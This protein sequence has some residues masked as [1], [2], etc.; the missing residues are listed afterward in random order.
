MATII[1][2][3]GGAGGGLAF[4]VVGGTTQPSNPSENTVWV[5]TSTAI[6]NVY[7]QVYAPANPV[8]GDVWVNTWVALDGNGNPIVSDPLTMTVAESPF[9]RITASSGKQW[10]GM[11]W[12][13]YPTKVYKNG[14]WSPDV[15]IILNAGS[16]GTF[17]QPT[18]IF[19]TNMEITG[20]NA[21]KYFTFENGDLLYQYPSSSTTVPFRAYIETPIDVSPYNTMKVISYKAKGGS[22]WA[23]LN[24][25]VS[26]GNSSYAES[27]A[28]EKMTGGTSASPTE[29][30]L[31]ISSASGQMYFGI[32]VYY[33]NNKPGA[34][35]REI[36]LMA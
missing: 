13:Q 21:A 18:K 3:G 29:T 31:D 20:T 33:N 1:R 9:I 25:S 12:V 24:S 22:R 8:V 7:A 2:V 14:A 30:N 32:G 17:G 19:Q 34:Y 11:G 10:N 6:K 4:T 16:W 28:T 36:C 5:N 26:G 15:L 35:F 23:F 27:Y